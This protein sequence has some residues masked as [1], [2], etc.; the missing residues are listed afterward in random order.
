MRY[1]YFQKIFYKQ[2]DGIIIINDNCS[3]KKG[4]EVKDMEDMEKTLEEILETGYDSEIE[5]VEDRDNLSW[6]LISGSWVL[7]CA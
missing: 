7:L 3:I 2:Y 5:T 1:I 6:L 4:K